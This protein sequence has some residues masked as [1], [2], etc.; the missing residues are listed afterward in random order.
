M[1][2][3]HRSLCDEHPPRPLGE[4]V[5]GGRKRVRQAAVPGDH[6]LVHAPHTRDVCIVS[7]WGVWSVWVCGACVWRV[8]RVCGCVG[9]VWGVWRVHNNHR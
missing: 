5:V 8:W 1:A 2:L 3:S 6:G 7:V 4:V 9:C